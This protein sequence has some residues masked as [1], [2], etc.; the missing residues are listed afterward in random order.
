MQSALL[1]LFGHGFRFL[2]EC[3]QATCLEQLCKQDES[4]LIGT[5]DFSDQHEAQ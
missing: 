1:S 3:E 2:G 4:G 5:E